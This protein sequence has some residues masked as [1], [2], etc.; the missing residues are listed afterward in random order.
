MGREV[1]GRRRDLTVCFHAVSSHEGGGSTKMVTRFRL[2]NSKLASAKRERARHS[3]GVSEA[4]E[5]SSADA[6]DGLASGV[7]LVVALL[8]GPQ[9]IVYQI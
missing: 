8:E 3:Q 9:P 5:I 6:L 1:V 4:R 2:G 7:A